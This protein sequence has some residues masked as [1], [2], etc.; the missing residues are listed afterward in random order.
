MDGSELQELTLVANNVGD[1]VFTTDAA[2]SVTFVSSSVERALGC[3]PEQARGTGLLEAVHSEDLSR[4]RDL[5]A[6]T[7]AGRPSGQIELRLRH[8]SSGEHLWFE[9]IGKTNRD[10]QGLLTGN[11]VVLRDIT[12]RRS[13]ETALVEAE[14]RY[15]EVI[16]AANEVIFQTDLRGDWSLL[17]P[18]WTVLTGYDVNACLG[19]SAPGFLHPDE[20][21][22]LATIL[23][24][25]IRS[26]N[27]APRR[28]SRLLTKGGQARWIELSVS[29]SRDA[30]GRVT[31]TAGTIRDVT[32]DHLR[33][34]LN[35]AARTLDRQ[36]LEGGEKGT[37][38][39]RGCGSLAAS[40]TYPLVSISLKQRDG[41]ALSVARRGYALAGLDGD[42]AQL[43]DALAGPG[44]GG[45][46]MRTGKT[47]TVVLAGLEGLDWVGLAVAAGISQV[48]AI[49]LVIPG[50][51]LGVLC[52]A[53]SGDDTLDAGHVSALESFAG[54]LS[55]A[56]QLAEHQALLALQGAAM[57][58]SSS[59]LFITDAHGRIE[60]VNAAFERMSGYTRDEAVGRT[61]GILRSEQQPTEP[62]KN[63]W[64]TVRSGNIWRGE[65]VN[66]RKT[67]E[68][69]LVAQ[70]VTPLLDDQGAVNHLVGTHEDVTARRQAET[71]VEHM[72]HHDALTDLP[73][74]ALFSDRL[75]AAINRAEHEKERVGLLFL[76]L[77][78]FKLV[79][80][81]LGHIVGDRLLREVAGRL[82]GCVR[83]RDLVARFG[84]DEFTVV[85]PACDMSV[86]TDV[87]ERIL[88]ALGQPMR[89]ANQDVTVSASIGIA[90]SSPD[91]RNADTLLRQADT[92]MYR[93]KEVGRNG[94]A[95]FSA[96]LDARPNSGLTIQAGLRRA[97][98]QG[99]LRL[100]YQPQMNASTGQVSGVEALLRWTSP[101]LGAVSPADFIP[102]AEQTGIIAEIDRWVLSAACAQARAWQIAGIEIPRVAVN[103][104]GVSF[105]RGQL[106]TWIEEALA[107][108]GLAPDRLEIEL[109]EG[110]VM[111]DGTAVIEAVAE[112]RKLGVRIAL[113]DFGTGYSSLSYLKRFK[114]DVLKID[115]SFVSGLPGDPDSAAIARLIVTMSKALHMETVAEC[116]E[117]AEQAAFLKSIGCDTLQ[118]YLFSP[119]IVAGLLGPFCRKH[120][121]G[122]DLASGPA[123]DVVVVASS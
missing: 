70:T 79:N 52:V 31:G 82:T 41:S 88:E 74:R 43:E 73:N 16:D 47:Q 55:L 65:I 69:Y 63:M 17:S 92:A 20:Q 95:F 36:I 106:L 29:P 33:N 57:A 34:S 13:T 97:L 26:R 50:A 116:V 77:D 21:A 98:A 118:G 105:R 58:S 111:H 103:V 12:A 46:A 113:D 90:L 30:S 44:P 123:P 23:A 110:I 54:R 3:A 39:Q 59:G 71:L 122:Q 45:V 85:L 99:E 49:P 1:I 11:V 61:P 42:S 37:V 120:A 32:R 86:A 91:T 15:R 25:V 78:R 104:S 4:L 5:F 94:Y 84:G 10:A 6:E 28:G 96:G 102:I 80:D 24:E 48:T 35:E 117:T 100:H 67:G 112:L 76:D 8:A 9:A 7:A 64:M 2:F 18:S 27:P 89:I 53:V 40:M 22:N 107:S 75:Q 121:G 114:L 68:T 72:A 109:T 51:V 87:A 66:R 56:L 119:G 81:T 108:S 14:A 38:L 83:D 115:G 19:R 101:V 93:A 62:F 60:W